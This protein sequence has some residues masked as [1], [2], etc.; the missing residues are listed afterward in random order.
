MENFYCVD[1]VGAAQA[2][3]LLL[4]GYAK[5]TDCKTDT[6]IVEF[7]PEAGVSVPYIVRLVQTIRPLSAL[8]ASDKPDEARLLNHRGGLIASATLTAGDLQ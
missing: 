6:V 1:P 4:S 2:K 5:A 7:T 8:L 3:A